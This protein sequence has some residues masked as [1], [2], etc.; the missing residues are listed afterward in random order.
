MV[1]TYLK[2]NLLKISMH[3]YIS[4]LNSYETY[5]NYDS[6][7]YFLGFLNPSIINLFI[8]SKEITI[9]HVYMFNLGHLLNSKINV[10]FRTKMGFYML[11]S[12][13][14]PR[15]QKETQSSTEKMRKLIMLLQSFQCL[16]LLMNESVTKHLDKKKL[17]SVLLCFLCLLSFF[18][19][20]FQILCSFN[21]YEIQFK[22]ICAANSEN[23][24]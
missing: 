12:S 16:H 15:R 8:L 2:R 7:V 21:A 5:K 24:L 19:F 23:F 10:F 13:L 4:K 14:M 1:F 6:L 3:A 11:K 22:A 18:C 20:F 17:P 9:M